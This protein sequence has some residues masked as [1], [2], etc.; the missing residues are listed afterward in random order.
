MGSDFKPTLVKMD[1]DSGLIEKQFPSSGLDINF[2]AS[3]LYN[4]ASFYSSNFDSSLS[5]YFFY[6]KTSKLYTKNLANE[7]GFT[8]TL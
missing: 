3:S 5:D 8:T 2:D 1:F 4:S 7:V 6:G